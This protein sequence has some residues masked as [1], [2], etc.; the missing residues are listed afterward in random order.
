[1]IGGFSNT[2]IGLER[3]MQG[4]TPHMTTVRV[5]K[6]RLSGETG[7]ACY[8]SYQRDTGRLVETT[9]AH[10]E[11]DSQPPID[12]GSTISEAPTEENF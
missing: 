12:F 6:N 7:V 5:V 2:V 10:A 11:N 9:P 3:D 1:M 4:D 8:L